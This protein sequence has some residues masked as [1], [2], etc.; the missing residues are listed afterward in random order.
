MTFYL[1]GGATSSCFRGGGDSRSLSTTSC[2]TPTSTTA[3]SP[4]DSRLY[5]RT[6]I[7][8][9]RLLWLSRG[10]GMWLIWCFECSCSCH[11]SFSSCTRWWG[12]FWGLFTKKQTPRRQVLCLF[13]QVKYSQLSG[14]GWGGGRGGGCGFTCCHGRGGRVITSWRRVKLYEGKSV[15]FILVIVKTTVYMYM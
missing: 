3:S 1:L 11:P 14:S 9:V 4:A 6:Q 12:R 2:I 7:W 15:L 8:S 13:F 5:R 10:S